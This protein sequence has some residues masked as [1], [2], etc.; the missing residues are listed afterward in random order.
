[1][2]RQFRSCYL[3]GVT[4]FGQLQDIRETYD[5]FVSRLKR[6]SMMSVFPWTANRRR[7]EPVFMG[8]YYL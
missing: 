8:N 6:R 2:N 5:W 7:S 4:A 1:M 3:D